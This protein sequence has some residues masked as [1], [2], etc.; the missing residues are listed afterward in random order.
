MKLDPSYDCICIDTQGDKV[1]TP[2]V[3]IVTKE[4]TSFVA[5][6]GILSINLTYLTE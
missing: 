6:E 2:A 3:D 5:L 4:L 1:T